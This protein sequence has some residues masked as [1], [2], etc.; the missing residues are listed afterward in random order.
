MSQDPEVTSRESGIWITALESAPASIK[1]EGKADGSINSL[2]LFVRE[3]RDAL[4]EGE[5]RD[6]PD[7][8]QVRYASLGE[9]LFGAQG[10]FAANTADPGGDWSHRDLIPDGVRLL[11]G[12]ENDRTTTGRSGQLSPPDLTPPHDHSALAVAISQSCRDT[13][14]SSGVS[15]IRV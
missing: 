5:F 3:K 10:D 14:T 12:E 9:S 2:H 8:I 7:G 1:A 6:R 15:G 4:P 13:A 11:S